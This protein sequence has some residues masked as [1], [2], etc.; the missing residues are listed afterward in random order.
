MELLQEKI[1]IIGGGHLSRQLI[2]AAKKYGLYV[3]I[4]DPMP[5]CAAHSLSDHHIVADYNDASAI[6]QLASLSTVLT[7]AIE[8]IDLEPLLALQ[9]DRYH[10]YPGPQVLR[11]LQDRFKQKQHLSKHNVP[12]SDFCMVAGIEDIRLAAKDLGYPIVLKTCMGSY[13]G[14]S[15]VIIESPIE[16]AA[17]FI[18]LGTGRVPIMVEQFVPC[19][20]EIS[21]ICCRNRDSNMCLY[22]VAENH[23]EGNRLIQTIVP[24]NI[25]E[26]AYESAIECANNSLRAFNCTGISC[27]DMF[28][29]EIDTIFVNRVTAFP[30]DSGH[31]TVEASRTSQFENH[32]RAILRLPLGDASLLT[33]AAT[34]ILYAN[35][36]GTPSVQGLAELTQTGL[37]LHLYGGDTMTDGQQ[38]GH[39]TLTADTVYQ[40]VHTIDAVTKVLSVIPTQL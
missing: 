22:T 29:T 21:V 3:T 19:M 24:A 34:R 6:Q 17:A 30:H 2:L 5:D 20:N 39:Y 9:K 37:S 32:I 18:A 14:K 1:G 36:T 28:V 8:Q 25:S 13:N 38:V 35:G 23:Y 15:L 40:A 26:R 7:I 4:L 33:P 27:V 11:L 31:F 12:V 10:I 16:I